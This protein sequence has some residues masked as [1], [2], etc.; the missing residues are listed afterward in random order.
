ML[1][2][3]GDVFSLLAS[4]GLGADV[5]PHSAWIPLEFF[6]SRPREQPN[7]P[8]CVHHGEHKGGVVA[9]VDITVPH[10]F[11]GCWATAVQPCQGGGREEGS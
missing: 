7:Y 10:G 2:G 11:D 4:D 9:Q 6:S 3:V 1:V 8:V 5:V